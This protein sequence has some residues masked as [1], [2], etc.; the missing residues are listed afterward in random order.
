MAQLGARLHGM[1]EVEGSN[2]SRSTIVQRIKFLTINDLLSVDKF[3][4]PSE[5]Y[6]G[7]CWW[8]RAD[9]ANAR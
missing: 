8:R 6:V 1:E 3:S 4:A 7:I 2:P 5:R 9:P